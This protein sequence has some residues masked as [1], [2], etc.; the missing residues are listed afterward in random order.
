[1]SFGDP[2]KLPDPGQIAALEAAM[3]ESNPYEPEVVVNPFAEKEAELSQEELYGTGVPKCEN[4]DC[5][6]QLKLSGGL[7]K[8]CNKQCRKAARAASHRARRAARRIGGTTT[9]ESQG[10]GSTT[11][12]DEQ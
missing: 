3:E 7:K 6:K 12:G 5:Q 4:P 8:Y 10:T 2:N 11:S 9:P 1:M